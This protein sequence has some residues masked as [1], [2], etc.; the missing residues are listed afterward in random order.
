MDKKDLKIERITG[1]GPG[2]QHRNKTASCVRVTHLPTGISVCIDG[3]HQGKNLKVALK[4]LERRLLEAKEQAKAEA[5][6]ARRDYAIRNEETIRHYDFKRG[7]VKD[8]RTGKEASIKDVLV[9]GMI[10]LVAPAYP[11]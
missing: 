8:L 2:G 10:E 11:A 7:L 3:R 5:K 4:E 1:T 9:K 6:K